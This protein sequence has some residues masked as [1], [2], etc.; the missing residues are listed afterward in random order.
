V[1]ADDTT[2]D[3]LVGCLPQ[4]EGREL[5][6]RRAAERVWIDHM[7]DHLVRLETQI[8]GVK[9]DLKADIG[10][11]KTDLKADIDNVKTGLEKYMTAREVCNLAGEHIALMTASHAF[12]QLVMN[13]D[14]Q[15]AA[16]LEQEAIALK[17]M[18][19]A[20]AAAA[21]IVAGFDYFEKRIT[22]QPKATQK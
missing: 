4:A 10:G 19:Y 3:H 7:K 17:A 16:L 18:G 2:S 9:T 5:I 6:E 11:V 13:T 1:F 15:P 21:A 12:A 20:A 22:V 14:T 8:G